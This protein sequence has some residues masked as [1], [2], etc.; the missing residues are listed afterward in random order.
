MPVLLIAEADMPGEAHAGDRG[1]DDVTPREA[2]KALSVTRAAAP[3]RVGA[4]GEMIS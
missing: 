3:E 1:Q 4:T 2:K